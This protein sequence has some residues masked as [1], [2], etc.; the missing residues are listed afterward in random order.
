MAEAI[1]GCGYAPSEP[2]PRRSY[3]GRDRGG[4]PRSPRGSPSGTARAVI[5]TD[6]WVSSL[7]SR[8]GA[9]ARLRMAYQAGSFT[10]I[11]SEPLLTELESVLARPRLTRLGIDA[12]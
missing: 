5:H 7:L 1:R 2:H 4:G 6:I 3:P 11:A 12:R 8:R 10:A 9:P